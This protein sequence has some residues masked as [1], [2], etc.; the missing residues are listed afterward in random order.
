MGLDRKTV[1][2]WIAGA[3]FGGAAALLSRMMPDHLAP[4]IGIPLMV[5]CLIGAAVAIVWA[6]APNHLQNWRRHMVPVAIMAVAVV[7]FGIGATWYFFAAQ[8]DATIPTQKPE[9]PAPNISFQKFA[10]FWVQTEPRVYH[11]GV[12]AKLFNAGDKS[13]YLDGLTFERTEW[14]MIPRGS[15]VIRR[16]IE[17][18]DKVD[19]IDPNFIKPNDVGYYKKL[20]PVRWDMTIQ[21]GVLPDFVLIGKWNATIGA[22]QIA[23]EPRGF[24]VCNN[25]LSEEQW[26]DLLKP[27]SQID[28]ENLNYFPV[29]GRLSDWKEGTVVGVS[30]LPTAPPATV[31]PVSAPQNPLPVPAPALPIDNRGGIFNAGPNSGTQTVINAVPQPRV[32]DDA[33]KQKLLASIPNGKP[34]TVGCDMGDREAINYASSIW[35]FL[36]AS[37]YNVG[38]DIIQYSVPAD[39]PL[40]INWNKQSVEAPVQIT[41]GKNG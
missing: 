38:T 40:V 12:I 36:K 19:F 32:L 22:T 26:T 4:G 11:L 24:G 37:G 10:L 9:E 31:P 23:L 14:K 20:L 2:G 41:V 28:I 34:V 25:P 27:K 3:L 6:T 17:F 13:H 29:P 21:G 39:G 8:H 18:P 33:L 16:Y 35:S 7:L 1:G 15:Y 5:A 30:C